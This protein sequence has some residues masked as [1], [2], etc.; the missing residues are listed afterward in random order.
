MDGPGYARVLTQ[1]AGG[2]AAKGG[3]ETQM[4]ACG[5]NGREE[6]RPNGEGDQEHAERRRDFCLVRD[7]E[8][9]R[10]FW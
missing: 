1:D 3:K 10:D 7:A 9:C 4:G 2:G 5:L 8:F 6:E